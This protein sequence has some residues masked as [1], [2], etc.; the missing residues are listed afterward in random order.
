[1]HVVMIL[2]RQPRSTKVG[3]VVPMAVTGG[4]DHQLFTVVYWQ[5]WW[6]NNSLL[7]SKRLIANGNVVM[8]CGIN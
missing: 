7:T 5:P 1:M 8:F 4:Y 3:V 2:H 6:I